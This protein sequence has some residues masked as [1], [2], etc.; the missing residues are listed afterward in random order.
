MLELLILIFIVYWV[1]K[2]KKREN[3]GNSAP[4]HIPRFKSGQRPKQKASAVPN[5]PKRGPRTKEEVQMERRTRESRNACDFHAAYSKGKPGRIGRR[6]DY[7]PATPQG[8]ERIRC[9]YCN[10]ENFVPAGSRDHYHCYFCWEK[11]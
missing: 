9:P 10:A 4:F 11:L 5:Q 8:M 3:P 7:E 6:G 2:R 1:R